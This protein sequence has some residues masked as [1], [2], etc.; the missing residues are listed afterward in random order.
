MGLIEYK[1]NF[2]NEIIEKI[3]SYKKICL[4]SNTKIN[5]L[6]LEIEKTNIYAPVTGIVQE[7]QNF[8]VGDYWVDYYKNGTT[9]Y[10]EMANY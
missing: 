3:K 4:D 2:K 5:N 10:W 1:I 6:L 8:N 9:Q 7:L